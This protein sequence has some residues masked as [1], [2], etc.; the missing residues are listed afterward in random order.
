MFARPTIVLSMA[1]SIPKITQ[2]MADPYALALTMNICRPV[3][4]LIHTW[5]HP[6]WLRSFASAMESFCITLRKISKVNELDA[7]V[8]S[9]L[10][11]NYH[12]RDIEACSCPRSAVLIDWKK[13]ITK[14]V[15]WCLYSNVIHI[16]SWTNKDETAQPQAKLD[17]YQKKLMVLCLLRYEGHGK[18]WNTINSSKLSSIVNNRN[19]RL[20]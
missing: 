18:C 1:N 14:D 9:K 11:A 8:Q 10:T 19:V 5:Q 16:R 17:F 3:S 4:N 15:R 20:T 6:Y 2:E 13:N 12:R 7:W